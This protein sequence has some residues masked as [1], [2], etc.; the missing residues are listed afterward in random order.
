MARRGLIS[1]KERALLIIAYQ[2]GNDISLYAMSFGLDDA[3]F[4][5]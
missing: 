5:G 2:M 3:E 1:P 4:A